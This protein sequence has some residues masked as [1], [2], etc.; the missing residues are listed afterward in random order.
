M[1]LNEKIALLEFQVAELEQKIKD[2]SANTEQKYKNPTSIVGGI[3]DRSTI[4]P[5]DFSAGKGQE[6]GGGVIWNDSELA[7]PP[8]DSEPPLPS[9]GYNKHTHSRFSGGALL[10]DGVEVVEFEAGG[11]S[12]IHSQQYWQDEPEIKTTINSNKQTV[13]KIGTLELIFDADTKKW[14][15]PAYEIDVK[16]CYLVE[17]DENGDI[18]MA[19]GQE[20]KSPLY[21]SDITKTAIIWDS[22]A[23]VWRFLAVYAPGV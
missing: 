4:H 21:N 18:A 5:V 23:G 22:N 17:R 13:D 15:S 11:I 7:L 16:K 8:A 20:K 1:T 9:K 10:K 6:C 3:R 2:L 14:G 12:N 19:N